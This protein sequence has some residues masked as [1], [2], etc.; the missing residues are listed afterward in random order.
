M[1]SKVDHELLAILLEG[2]HGAVV[3][4]HG[5]RWTLKPGQSG[6]PVDKLACCGGIEHH[7]DHSGLRCAD[8]T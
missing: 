4:M 1:A 5:Q 6:S 2:N 7:C 8:F 3:K